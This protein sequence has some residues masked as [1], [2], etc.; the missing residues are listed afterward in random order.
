MGS[1]SFSSPG[2]STRQLHLEY[3]CVIAMAFWSRQH[4]IRINGLTLSYLAHGDSQQF[5][6]DSCTNTDKLS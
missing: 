2:V 3:G 6:T 5:T 4:L 1:Y